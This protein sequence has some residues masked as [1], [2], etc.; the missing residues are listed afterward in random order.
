MIASEVRVKNVIKVDGK[1]FRITKIEHVKPGKGHA[2]VVFT[3]KNLNNTNQQKMRFRV[4]EKIENVIVQEK[5]VIHTYSN[6]E[7]FFFLDKDGDEIVVS[8]TQVPYKQLITAGMQYKI[9][10]ADDEIISVSLPDELEL[11]VTFAP[12]FIT[13][14]SATAQLKTVRTVH[15]IEIEVPQYI[16]KGDILKVNSDLEFISRV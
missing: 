7:M 12:P 6:N 8:G 11:E 9:I 16:K 15:D 2:Y 13:G 1:L 3:I 5:I 14:Q 10:Y 4:N